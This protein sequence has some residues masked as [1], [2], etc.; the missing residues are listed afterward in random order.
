ME[1]IMRFNSYSTDV[2]L[3]TQDDKGLIQEKLIDINECAKELMLVSSIGFDFNAL[4]I[5]NFN[6]NILYFNRKDNKDYYII[7]LPERR[8][9]C[10]YK[11]QG[12]SLIHPNAIFKI[13]INPT[14]KQYENI[15]AFCYKE[16][17]GKSTELYLYPFPNMLS[18]NRICTGTIST[19]AN[20][21]VQAIL[22]VIEG[23]Y[24][25]DKTSS[26]KIKDTKQFF[27]KMQKTFDYRILEKTGMILE[28]LL[29]EKIV[30]SW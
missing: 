18:S 29:K 16:Y 30:R 26:L 1:T 24:T 4:T 22:N 3:L 28:D 5:D 19:E 27:K 13:K 21:P 15:Q 10:T 17:K 6:E 14:T 2:E 11:N 25:H 7:R 12:Y 9:K 8:I 23:N 20:D